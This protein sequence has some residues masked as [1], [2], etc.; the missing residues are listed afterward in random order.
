MEFLLY[1]LVNL[2]GTYT[3]HAGIATALERFVAVDSAREC[4]HCQ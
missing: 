3:V 2:F 1:I 4:P